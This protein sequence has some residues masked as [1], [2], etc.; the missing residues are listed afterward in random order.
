MVIVSIPRFA[1]RYINSSENRFLCG[2]MQLASQCSYHRIPILKYQNQFNPVYKVLFTDSHGGCSILQYGTQFLRSTG[3]SLF[4][5]E[6]LFADSHGGCSMLQC[7]TQSLRSTGISLF[8]TKGYSNIRGTGTSLF[9][10]TGI[11][12][13]K[14]GWNCDL[15][16]SDR[17]SSELG[18][19]N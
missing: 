14:F 8:R 17:K 13:S 9:Q 18:T 4:R 2:L 15:V 19:N 11:L 5:T 3:I 7:G 10:C 16:S 6:F 12:A 1:M